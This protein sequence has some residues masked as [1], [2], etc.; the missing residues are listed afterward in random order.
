MTSLTSTLPFPEVY[1]LPPEV[2]STLSLKTGVDAQAQPPFEHERQPRN[3]SDADAGQDGASENLVGSQSCSLCGAS[4]ASVLDQ[5]SHLKSD[6][7]H[8]NLKQKLRGSKPASEAEF[9]KLI[10]GA[11][12]TRS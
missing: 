12:L 11:P 3:H 6:W 9:E 1:D 5:R 2:L 4:F 7:H 8:Y 10:G